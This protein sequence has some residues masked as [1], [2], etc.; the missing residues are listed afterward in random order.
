VTVHI[1]VRIMARF[2]WGAPAIIQHL[3]ATDSFFGRPWHSFVRYVGN[4]GLAHWGRLR[5]VLRSVGAVR[6]SCVLLQCM[7]RAAHRHRCDLERYGCTRLAWDFSM[8]DDDYP[9]LEIVEATNLLRA[10]DVQVDWED[11][12]DRLGLRATPADQESSPTERR[13]AR[14]FVNV[15]FPWTSRELVPGL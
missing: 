5:L 15:F 2:E 4:D 10:E 13:A 7:R 6:R 12:S 3:R 14:Y 9:A 1:T 11:L 8:T